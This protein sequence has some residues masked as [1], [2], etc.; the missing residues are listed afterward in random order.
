VATTRS[1]STDTKTRRRDSGS[2][3]RRRQR[4]TRASTTRE[5][6]RDAGSRRITAKNVNAQDRR[7]LDE[8]AG[9]LSPTTLRAKWIHE[10]NEHEDRPGQS[11]ATRSTDVIRAWA[12]ERGGQP[13]TVRTKKSDQPR[14]LRLDFPGYGGARLERIDWDAWLG[15]FE[16]RKL[17]FLF[18]EHKR[19][20][21]D[22][23]FF[24]LDNPERED[25]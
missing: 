7:F 14:T 3:D 5:R 10:P 17:V 20:G 8:H 11:L 24:R 15:T 6:G 22:S 21:S 2:E 23:N 19:D 1:T 12:E 13:A 25:G 18:Q 16:R 9:G 4:T